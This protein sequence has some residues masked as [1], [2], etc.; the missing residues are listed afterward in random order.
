MARWDFWDWC[1][2]G[3]LTFAVAMGLLVFLLFALPQEPLVIPEVQA[4]VRVA[5]LSQFPPNTARL[6]TWGHRLVLVIRTETGEVTAVAGRSPS[7]GCALE[8]DERLSR[9]QS[10]CSYQI[11]SPY[12]QVID[13][14][15]SQSL[16]RYPVLIRDSIINIGSET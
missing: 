1:L 9:I 2:A 11:Y 8:W 7:D 4:S 13:G 5:H 12:G 3:L 14:L 10:P 6:E 16:I 15:S